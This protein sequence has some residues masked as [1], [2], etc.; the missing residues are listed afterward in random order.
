MTAS[1]SSRPDLDA[2]RA[3]LLADP[4]TQSIAEALEVSIEAYVDQVLHYVANPQEEPQYAVLE[5]EVAESRGL[6]TFTELLSFISGVARGEIRGREKG[7]E[8]ED[9]IQTPGRVEGF[10]SQAEGMPPLAPPA[11]LPLPRPS[12]S[13]PPV[14]SHLRAVHNALEMETRR[15]RALRR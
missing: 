15:A 1:P 4:E 9:R 10:R 5:T 11:S 6:P 8:A 12:P 14:Q 2:L 13:K 3:R 7:F